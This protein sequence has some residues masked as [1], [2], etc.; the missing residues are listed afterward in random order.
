MKIRHRKAETRR[1]FE[2]A[3]RRE[4]EDRRR[5]EL[6]LAMRI[7]QYTQRNKRSRQNKQLQ[8]IRAER[9]ACPNR[10]RRRKVFA[11]RHEEQSGTR[12]CLP[13]N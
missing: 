1:G 12:V 11:A 4:H 5:L 13:V 3:T 7:R 6:S 9:R 8:D 10:H 2:A